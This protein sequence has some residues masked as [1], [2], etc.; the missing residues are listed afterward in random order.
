[1][2]YQALAL[3][4]R[5]QSFAEILE[6]PQVTQTLQNAISSGRIHHGYLFCGPRGTGKTTTAR[7]LAKALN[8]V[9]GPTP[10]P[11]GECEHCRAIK[12]SNSLDVL[13]ID[14][15]SNTGVDNIRDLRERAGYV[16][17]SARYKIYII[18]E[19]HRLSRSAFD[20]LLK[21]LEEP[22]PSVVFIF[23]TTEPNEVPP[24]VRSRTLRFD[25]RLISHAPLEAA[26]R[27]I[28]DK[29]EID[30]TDDALTI[31]ATEA[32]GSMRDGESL[33]DQ[34]AGYTG[35]QITAELVHE[36]LGLVNTEILFETTDAFAAHD[37]EAALAVVGRV[38][39]LGRDLTQYVRQLAEHIKRLLF[40]RALGDRF[41]DE[42]LNQDIVTRYRESAG[43]FEE[44]DLLRLVTMTVEMVNRLRKAP[45]PRLE[46]ELYVM[47]ASKMDRS[48]DIRTLVDRLDNSAGGEPSLFGS[49]NNTTSPTATSRPT[50][51]SPAMRAPAPAVRPSSSPS[52]GPRHSGYQ[53]RPR[54]EASAVATM[55]APPSDDADEKPSRPKQ[56]GPDI[57]FEPIL[58]S[59]CESRPT[60]RAILGQAELVRTG[61]GMLDLNVYHGSPF[62]QKQLGTK[63]VRDLIHAEIARALGEGVR[64]TIHVKQGEPSPK[65][66]EHKPKAK[67]Q[68]TD[69][70]DAIAGDHNLQEI[71]RRFDGEIIE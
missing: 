4:W 37:A 8:C 36:A 54:A 3:K 48:I 47:R 19:V 33:L 69:H 63:P 21:T 12:T 64:V 28:A 58:E 30:I 32:G 61:E 20:A 17:V 9:N 53:D 38:A 26:L 50:A 39:R 25:F 10:T 18:D 7:I 55:E 60:L 23:A 35:G 70:D 46:V 68:T 34:M 62:H 5:P 1:M 42:S 45:H 43:A 67:P 15:A 41:A 44:N 57:D 29:E 13:E 71:I 6:Q 27:N 51:S 65:A 14:A 16:P 59:I 22:P 24:T 2:D 11:C 49:S 52:T 56:T 66:R 31:L 40:A